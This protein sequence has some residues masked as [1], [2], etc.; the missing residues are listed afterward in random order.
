MVTL[1]N[2]G[3]VTFKFFTID[4]PDSGD[5]AAGVITVSPASVSNHH[6]NFILDVFLGVKGVLSSLEE[7][8]FTIQYLPGTPE[9]FSK[10]FQVYICL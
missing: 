2:T 3:K 9:P 1:T 8:K 10:S 5:L 4:V 6:H 7:Q